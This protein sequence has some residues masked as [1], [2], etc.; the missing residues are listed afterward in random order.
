MFTFPTSHDGSSGTKYDGPYVPDQPAGTT[1]PTS[2][3]VRRAGFFGAVGRF[4]RSFWEEEESYHSPKAG[5]QLPPHPRQSALA[6]PPNYGRAGLV[7][8]AAGGVAIGAYLPWITYRVGGV[9]QQFSGYR[10]GH[11]TGFLLAA[12]AFALAALLGARH[13]VMGWVTMAMSLVVAGLV[14]RQLLETHDQVMR[15][16]RS[17]AVDANL[18]VGLW[19]MLVA[20]AIGLIAAFRLETPREIS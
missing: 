16:N 4:F 11:S 8:L 14:S 18:G 3:D 1:K 7:M 6:P 10:L 2:D 12:A 19:V 13:R 9:T 20:A 5:V 15:L 17:I